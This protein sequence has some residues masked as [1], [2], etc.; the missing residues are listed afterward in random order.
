MYLPPR[1][2]E[3]LRFWEIV[4][5]HSK[6]SCPFR[7]NLY[8]ICIR[9]N[10]SCNTSNVIIVFSFLHLC[11]YQPCIYH[12]KVQIFWEGHKIWKIS[13]LSRRCLVMS[14]IERFFQIFVAFPELICVNPN[15]LKLNCPSMAFHIGKVIGF[16]ERSNFVS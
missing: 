9:T 5:K 12:S 1:W 15:I 11:T 4:E 16:I 8:I 10:F 7:L 6:Y 13:Q 2:V 3:A 14:N